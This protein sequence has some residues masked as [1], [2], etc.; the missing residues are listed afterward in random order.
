M[1]PP[2]ADLAPARA[3]RRQRFADDVDLYP[4]TCEELSAG[5]TDVQ[6]LEAVIAGGARIIQLRDKRASPRAFYEKACRFRDLTRAHGVP[7]FIND[8]VDI[9]LAVDADGVHLGQDDL[10]LP[11][12]RR[13]LP[14]QLLGAS[15]HN[16]A[17]A[18]RAEA[19]GA[20]YVNIGPLYPTATK[21]GVR[22]FLGPD[23]VRAI[24]P[25]LHIPFT[26]M[27]GITTAN[28]ADVLAAGARRVAVV[29]AIT[30][31]PDIAAAVRDWRERIRAAPRP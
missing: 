31:A 9:A 19:E 26:V 3:A 18:L 25:R 17:E 13:L 21:E 23:A 4:V 1:S 29:T 6:V 12:A 22:E 7:L 28:L 10:P 11:V 30:R 2:S 24:A 14:H 5:R 15:T 20:D 8:H 16:L 27:G